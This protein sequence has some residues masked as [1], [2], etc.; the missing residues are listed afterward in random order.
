M[1][2]AE[3]LKIFTQKACF[4]GLKEASESVNI[5]YHQAREICLSRNIK[6]LKKR[7]SKKKK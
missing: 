6:Y 1:L 7:T 5:T 4:L 3:E 2:N